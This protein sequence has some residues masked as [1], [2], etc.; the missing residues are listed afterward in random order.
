[1]QGV[2]RV[3]ADV[4][5]L[6]FSRSNVIIC[7]RVFQTAWVLSP[8][9]VLAVIIAGA[10]LLLVNVLLICLCRRNKRKKYQGKVYKMFK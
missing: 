6:L 9:A 3:A 7:W 1:M 8:A 4:R 2:Y 10:V 5:R